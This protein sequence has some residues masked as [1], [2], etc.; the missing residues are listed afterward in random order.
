MV[1]IELM[2]NQYQIN[3]PSNKKYINE[4][5]SLS[6]Y[7]NKEIC[8]EVLLN[9]FNYGNEHSGNVSRASEEQ[10]L[11]KLLDEVVLA[12]LHVLLEIVFALLHALLE[13]LSA[14]LIHLLQL[15]SIWYRFDVAQVFEFVDGKS[16]S[17]DGDKIPGRRGHLVE[18][19]DG[20][21]I[22]SVLIVAEEGED[23]FRGVQ[24]LEQGDD[25][26]S[27][28]DGVVENS[29][30]HGG[31]GY[32]HWQQHVPVLLVHLL[33]LLEQGKLLFLFGFSRCRLFGN[34][35]LV[36]P[37]AESSRHIPIRRRSVKEVSLLIIRR[38]KQ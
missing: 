12:L 28:A 38:L 14:L 7:S 22:A 34:L 2:L 9:R 32:V 15:L 10:S 11:F 4:P 8:I 18:G 21:H 30:P 5:S 23:F 37:G 3:R 13:I 24:F 26:H 20:G 31:G 19:I 6:K 1:T 29:N 33:E 17:T 36:G 16:G 27:S 25:V 35:R